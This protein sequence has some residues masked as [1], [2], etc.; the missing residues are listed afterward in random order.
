MGFAVSLA[1]AKSAAR[2]AAFARRKVAHGAV[3]PA[4]AQGLLAGLL[5]AEAPGTVVSLYDPIRTEIDPRPAVAGAAG[6]LRLAMPVIAGPGLP[7]AFRAW[8]PGATME[9]GPFGVAVPAVG[10]TLE[11]TVL[12]VPMLAFDRRGF[13]LGY[14]GGFF[15][16][17]L[18]GLRAGGGRVRAIGYAF[19]AQQVAELP[20]DPTDEPLDVIVTETGL[21]RPVR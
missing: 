11:P 18:A 6:R 2:A 12:V 14:G 10:D 7:L 20:V 9:P 3:D 17:T 1:E 5:A 15:D 4:P 19:A 13:R 16:R 8:S 21:L